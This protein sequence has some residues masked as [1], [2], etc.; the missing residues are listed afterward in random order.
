[1][2]AATARRQEHGGGD[3]PSTPEYDAFGP[4]VDPVRTA[5]EVPPLYR[6]HPVDL[7]GSR[8][9]LSPLDNHVSLPLQVEP[10]A[11]QVIAWFEAGLRNP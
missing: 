10:F 1:M 2:N 5:E 3:A 9:V 6:D 7:A 8:L 4:W 11:P